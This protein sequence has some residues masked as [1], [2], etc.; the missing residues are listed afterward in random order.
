MLLD[1]ADSTTIPSQLPSDIAVAHK[2]GILDYVRGDAGIIYAS[3]PIVM[4]VFVEDFSST[5]E[6][7]VIIGTIARIAIETYGNQN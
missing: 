1:C 7:E 3:Q 6:A 5:E 4:S 2:T